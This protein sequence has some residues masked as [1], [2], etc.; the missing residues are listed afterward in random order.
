MDAARAPHPAPDALLRFADD[1]LPAQFDPPRSYSLPDIRVQMALFDRLVE[2]W[3]EATIVPSL[4]E[5]W[6]VADDGLRYTFRLREGLRWSDGVPLTAADVEFGIKR[7][8]DPVQPGV[9]ASIFFVLEG[10]QDRLRGRAE[11]DADIGVRALDER[12]VEFRLAAPAPYFLSVVNRPDG[13]PVPRHV[14]ERHGDDWLAPDRQVVSGAFRQLERA[15]DR[16]VL[17]RR[18]D[19][20]RPGNVARVE[21]SVAT[22]PRGGVERYVRGELDVVVVPPLIDP[23]RDGRRRDGGP[24]PR[25]AIVDRLPRLRS[26]WRPGAR[27]CVPTRAQSVVRPSRARRAT[28]C[29]PLAGDGRN[30]S[31]RAPGTYAGRAPSFDPD[32]ARS[33][34][35]RV[36]RPRRPHHCVGG[37]QPLLAGTVE[38]WRE[39]LGDVV[40]VSIS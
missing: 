25:A 8:L 20:G 1:R 18:L 33:E 39:I 37:S 9:S 5:S 12:T 35:R 23:G 11:T 40:E 3:P 26:P 2:R 7:G 36:T 14:I 28:A 22:G 19:A 29:E 38:T 16:V 17:E 10:A 27:S 21:V 15:P 24:R 31:A 30:R 34:L 6:A 13:G 32:A 4:A